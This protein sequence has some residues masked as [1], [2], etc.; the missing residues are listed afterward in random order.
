MAEKQRIPCRVCGKLFEPCA[1][2][3]SHADTFRWRNFACSRECA[4]KYIE[5]TTAYRKSLHNTMKASG[6]NSILL[7]EN[8]TTAKKKGN[9][10]LLEN[11]ESKKEEKETD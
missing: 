10:K 4:T 9:K 7:N 5:E 6:E 1:Y 2:C 11:T 3:K 8:H